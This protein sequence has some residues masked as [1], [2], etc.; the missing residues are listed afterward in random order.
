MTDLSSEP[1]P[2]RNA[3]ADMAGEL[4]AA[5]MADF[6][7]RA[8]CCTL[9]A[10]SAPGGVVSPYV[11]VANL[12][13]LLFPEILFPRPTMKDLTGLVACLLKMGI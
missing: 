7:C 8:N 11:E 4:M 5:K 12:I 13:K 6:N 3:M 10:N 2:E 1:N 9:L